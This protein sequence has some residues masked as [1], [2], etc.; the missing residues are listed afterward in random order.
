MDK[1]PYKITKP[2]IEWI[3]GMRVQEGEPLMLT[4]AQ[5]AHDLAR[6]NIVLDDT[7]GTKPPKKPREE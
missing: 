6:G 4:E 2:D 7:A 3:A 5:A 1:K